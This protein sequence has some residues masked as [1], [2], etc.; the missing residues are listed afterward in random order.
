MHCKKKILLFLNKQVKFNYL[1]L[2][3]LFISLL[4]L[5]MCGSC[6]ATVNSFPFSIFGFRGFPGSFI[7]VVQYDSRTRAW[8]SQTLSRIVVVVAPES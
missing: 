6:F 4:F 7:T 8:K 3:L 5:S 1:F 2:F